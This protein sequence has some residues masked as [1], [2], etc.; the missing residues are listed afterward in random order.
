MVRKSKQIEADK[1]REAEEAELERQDAA[2]QT[3]KFEFPDE[4]ILQAESMSCF[5][6]FYH[7]C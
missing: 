7:A 2:K 4:A 1:A 5:I 3:A 6:W